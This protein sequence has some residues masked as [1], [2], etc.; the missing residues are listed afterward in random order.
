MLKK[1][2]FM[3]VNVFI[4]LAGCQQSFTPPSVASPQSTSAEVF[5]DE[6]WKDWEGWTTYQNKE[7]RVISPEQGNILLGEERLQ[8][9]ISPV[10]VANF[11]KL[12]DKYNNTFVLGGKKFGPTDGTKIVVEFQYTVP[13]TYQG[14]TGLWVEKSNIIVDGQLTDEGFEG[15]FGLNYLS[16]DSEASG[17]AGLSFAYF[18]GWWPLCTLKIEGVDPFVQNTYRIEWSK[19]GWAGYVNGSLVGVCKNYEFEEGEIQL[20]ADN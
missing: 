3:M 4:L 11:E 6:H 13:S 15:A 1:F 12:T 18:E 16:Y 8:L 20:W 9:G 2:C 19:S 7:G 14:S 10:P 5:V 17:M